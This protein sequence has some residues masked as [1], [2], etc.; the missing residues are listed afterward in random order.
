MLSGHRIILLVQ[1]NIWLAGRFVLYVIGRFYVLIR[2]LQQLLS[3]SLAAL[4]ALSAVLGDLRHPITRLV[5]CLTVFF[6]AMESP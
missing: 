1:G 6:H 5:L 4:L 3:K 2:R